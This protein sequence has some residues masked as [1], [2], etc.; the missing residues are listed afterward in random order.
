MKNK[1]KFFLDSG[2]FTAWS[3]GVR[4]SLKKYMEF[5]EK[6]HDMITA[7]ANLDAIG[8]VE[9]TWKNQAKMEHAGFK[10]LPIYH[11]E[12]PPE[13]LQKCIAEYD[14]FCLGGMARGYGAEAR[15]TFLDKWFKEICTTPEE[16]PVAKIHGFGLTDL[17]LM[18]RYPWHSV[19]SFTPIISA[20]WGSVLLPKVRHD[21]MH[22]RS[23][24]FYKA[25]SQGTHKTGAV[26]S[27]LSL[28]KELQDAYKE[29]FTKYDFKLGQVAY[30][31]QRERRKKKEDN[32]MQSMFDL[33][34]K[35]ENT[36]ERTLANSWEERV[37]W[38]LIMWAKLRER[39]PLYPRKFLEP[40]P[41]KEEIIEGEKTTMYIGAATTGHIKMIQSVNCNLDVLVSFAY[42]TDDIRNLLKDYLNGN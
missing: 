34:I 19:D 37:R 23:I 38:N 18:L 6:N 21:G 3:K 8:D 26:N 28:P 30:I 17:E 40:F 20:I 10:P 24:D 31:K 27:F 7:Y 1:P 39:L 2:A 9:R 16:F 14:H 29:L 13:Y 33:E 12:D 35:D 5:I 25:S 36:E 4:I 32:R 41:S 22:Y 15:K 42:M 11:T